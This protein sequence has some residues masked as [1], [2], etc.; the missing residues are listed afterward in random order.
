MPKN[1]P[2]KKTGE[3]NGGRLGEIVRVLIRNKAHKGMNPEKLCRILEDLGPTFVKLGQIMASRPDILPKEYCL[4]LER[5]RTNVN[6]MPFEEVAAALERELGRPVSEVFPV[7]DPEPLGSA[8]IA[9]AHRAETADGRAVVVKIQRPNIREIMF[10]D[11]QLLRRASGLVKIVTGTGS[12]IDFPAF[13]DEMESVTAEELNFET[14][15]ANLKEFAANNAGVAYARCPEVLE[16]LSSERLLVME[17]VD[18]I[19]IDDTD[20]LKRAGYDC[21]EIARK[22]A[23]NYIRQITEDGFFHADPH[24]GNLLVFGGQIVWID[25]GMMGRLT[26][27]QRRLFRE[28]V[29]AILD[30]D[31]LRI[32][33]ILLQLG[34]FDNV[35][36]A[37]LYRGIDAMLTKYGNMGMGNFDV[38]VIVN[39]LLELANENGVALPKGMTMF[40]RGILTIESTLSALSPELNI[41]EMMRTAAREFLLSDLDW[42]REV[43]KRSFE[44]FRVSD[45][46]SELPSDLSQYLKMSIAGVSTVN[47]ELAGAKRYARQLKIFTLR[48]VLSILSAA[49]LIAAGLFANTNVIGSIGDLSVLSFCMLGGAGVFAL[50]VLLSFLIKPRKKRKFIK[51]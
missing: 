11:L 28:G 35:D 32:K 8:S 36:D 3:K 5:L 1:S 37:G 27:E 20:A 50:G 6:P 17:F 4:R 19:R 40:A 26:P 31:C 18:G 23:D 41:M 44:L 16:E 21:E 30:H 47:V 42:K 25:L 12:A 48:I 34:K 46:L 15:C 14:E 33:N 49:L 51:K 10:R 39:E 7:L 13:L 29:R 45:K 24:A 2:A 9:Q 22:L 38:G 43:Q